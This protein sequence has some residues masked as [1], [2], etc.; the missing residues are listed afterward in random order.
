M[1]EK[2]HGYHFEQIIIIFLLFMLVVLVSTLAKDSSTQ[3]QEGRA[4]V[5]KQLLQTP[6]PEVF[7]SHTKKTH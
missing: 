2:V 3:I 1:Q 5:P 6:S 4:L 7:S